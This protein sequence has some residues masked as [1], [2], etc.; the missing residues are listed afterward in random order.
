MKL[1][2][3]Q[4]NEYIQH[5][6]NDA[7]DI[8]EDLMLYEGAINNFKNSLQ[9][10]NNTHQTIKEII[11]NAKPEYKEILKDFLIYMKYSN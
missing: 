5:Y 11:I 1:S 2:K 10:S 8:G 6:L 7:Y 4:L 9:E 3:Q